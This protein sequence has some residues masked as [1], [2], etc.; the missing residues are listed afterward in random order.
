MLFIAEEIGVGCID[1][2]CF[3]IMIFDV[4]CISFLD[5]EKIFISNVFFVSPVSFFN[6]LL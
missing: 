5:A 2:K 6:V 4:V 3:Y 1:E